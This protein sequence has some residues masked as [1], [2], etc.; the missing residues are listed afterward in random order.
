MELS[1]KDKKLLFGGR[2]KLFTICA[3]KKAK[4][5][6]NELIA[7]AD[8]LLVTYSAVDYN[9]FGVALNADALKT[10]LFSWTKK[11]NDFFKEVFIGQE[12][13]IQMKFVY[14]I[15]RNPYGE[16]LILRDTLDKKKAFLIEFQEVLAAL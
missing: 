4:E 13:D 1:Q 9:N 16:Y 11:V 7:E 5:R 2:C 3:R 10:D 14:I 6:V 8:Q 12:S 15:G